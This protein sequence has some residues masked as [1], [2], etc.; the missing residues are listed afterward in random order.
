MKIECRQI[1]DNNDYVRMKTTIQLLQR[2]D[3][4]WTISRRIHVGKVQS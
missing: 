2:S 4:F 3:D 1:D